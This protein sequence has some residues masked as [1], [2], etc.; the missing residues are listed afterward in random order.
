[1]EKG[2]DELGGRRGDVWE[3]TSGRVR[4]RERG[5]WRRERL[6]VYEQD[7]GAGGGREVFGRGMRGRL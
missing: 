2:R 3:R 6:R 5:R 7:V 4:W 1:M